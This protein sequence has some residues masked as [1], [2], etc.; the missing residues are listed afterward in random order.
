MTE[1]HAVYLNPLVLKDAKTK[2]YRQMGPVERLPL[3]SPMALCPYSGR[4]GQRHCFHVPAA[5]LQTGT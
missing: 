1:L 5:A 4:T 3:Q 2:P